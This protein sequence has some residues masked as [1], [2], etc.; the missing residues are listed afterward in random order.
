MSTV[1]EIEARQA[2]ELADVWAR[3]LDTKGGRLIAWDL[4]EQ[5]GVFRST[6]SS[7]ASLAAFQEGRRSIGL[8]IMTRILDTDPSLFAALTNEGGARADEIER[9]KQQEKDE[10]G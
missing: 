2:R 4:M 1:D 7:D 9:A 6:Y 8:Q 3:M 5:A 10:D